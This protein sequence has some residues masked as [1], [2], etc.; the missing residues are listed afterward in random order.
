ME[1]GHKDTDLFL[2]DQKNFR[3]YVEKKLYDFKK[4]PSPNAFYEKGLSLHRI[5][6]L[7]NKTREIYGQIEKYSVKN[8]HT[9]VIFPIFATDFMICDLIIV[10]QNT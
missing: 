2:F 6:L 7:S 1:F 9:I 10:S 8:L 4:D 5:M 3:F